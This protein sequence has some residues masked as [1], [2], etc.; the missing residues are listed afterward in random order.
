MENPT[1]RLE[2]SNSKNDSHSEATD[3]KGNV[4]SPLKR[5]LE[6][7]SEEGRSIH[8]STTGVD[9]C[10]NDSSPQREAP[11]APTPCPLPQTLD[12]PPQPGLIKIGDETY[13]PEQ[14][15]K[16]NQHV[17]GLKYIYNRYGAP[18]RPESRPRQLPAFIDEVS[19]H[20]ENGGVK[21]LPSGPEDEGENYVGSPQSVFL[22][23]RHHRA[24]RPRQEYTRASHHGR[25]D[26]ASQS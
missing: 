1:S 11:R 13:E 25:K 18:H 17:L 26:D 4:Q 10:P 7:Y 16:R 5:K 22:E 20:Y 14:Y 9:D 12:Q 24:R 23:Y 21:K 6:G 15:T 3:N 8:S 19:A 2:Q